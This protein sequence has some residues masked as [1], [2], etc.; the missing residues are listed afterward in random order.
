MLL[1]YLRSWQNKFIRGKNY[2]KFN[3]KITYRWIFFQRKK[4]VCS[5][6]TNYKECNF[7]I[8]YR[9]SFFQEK[10][11]FAL[12]FRIGINGTWYNSCL[13][14]IKS[15]SQQISFIKSIIDYLRWRDIA[16]Y[17]QVACT[18]GGFKLSMGWI[19]TF[20]L[21]FIR[22]MRIYPVDSDIQVNSQLHMAR[23][24]RAQ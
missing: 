23:I 14:F 12:G 22:R 20:C 17:M 3:F 2:M 11:F 9:W 15:D 5:R 10:K 16:K 8:T 18:K 1:P 13:Y 21:E 6:K 24:G 19:S 4:V 7:K